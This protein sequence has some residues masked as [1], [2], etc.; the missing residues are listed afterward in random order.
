MAKAAASNELSEELAKDIAPL[1][2]KQVSPVAEVAQR[3]K[4][5]PLQPSLIQPM[6]AKWETWGIMARVDDTFEDVTDPGY[7][8]AKQEAIKPGHT[9]E[10]KHPLGRFVVVLDVVN[11]DAE[12]QGIVAYV[13]HHFDYS[14]SIPDIVPSLG[15]A[16][17]K[18]MG[19]R[20]WAVVNGHHLVKDGFRTEEKALEWLS[21]KKI[22]SV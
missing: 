11:V 9:I 12:S 3:R 13:R 6:G 22:G 17:V 18:Y 8:F 1:P 4:V 5:Q 16:E 7:L 14:K 10:I 21:N 2:A 20:G 19:A 15:T